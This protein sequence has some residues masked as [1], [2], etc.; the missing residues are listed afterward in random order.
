[1]RGKGGDLKKAAADA[2]AVRYASKDADLHPLPEDTGDEFIDK[3]RHLGNMEPGSAE[4]SAQHLVGS[5]APEEVMEVM[6]HVGSEG[7]GVT[8]VLDG[9]TGEV[10]ATPNKLIRD[11]R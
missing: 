8:H 11:W 9:K 3:L 6:G 5:M 4:F 10:I 2:R 7:I 1:V